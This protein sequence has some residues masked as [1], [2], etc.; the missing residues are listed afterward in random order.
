MTHR[1]PQSHVVSFRTLILVGVAIVGLG[2]VISADVIGAPVIASTSP[3]EAGGTAPI[4]ASMGPRRMFS[5][6]SRT[7]KNGRLPAAGGSPNSLT[8]N[9]NVAMQSCF[10]CHAPG[11]DRD[12]VFTQYSP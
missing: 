11:K 1:N 5:S 2:L 4:L 8:A 12:F 7:H 9:H 10:A 6:W 3:Q